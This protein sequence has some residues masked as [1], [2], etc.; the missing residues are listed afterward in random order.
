[1]TRIFGKRL[2]LEF[3]GGDWIMISVDDTNETNGKLLK[4]LLESKMVH[5]LSITR[6]WNNTKVMSWLRVVNPSD[7]PRGTLP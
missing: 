2:G 1:M 7:L 6:T 5:H 4:L 3:K